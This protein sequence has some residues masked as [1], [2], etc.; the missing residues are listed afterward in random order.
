MF[1]LLTAV[2]PVF[3][4]NCSLNTLWSFLALL[5]PNPGQRARS[6]G[7]ARMMASR[8]LKVPSSVTASVLLTLF[9][10]VKASINVNIN[11]AMKCNKYL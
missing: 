11:Y 8:V 4:L 3:R 10:L 9:T 1:R 6:S 7:E 5:G 2:L